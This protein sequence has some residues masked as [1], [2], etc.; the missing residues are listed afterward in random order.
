MNSDVTNPIGFWPPTPVRALAAP[1]LAL[2][3]VLPLPGCL[4]LG[5]VEGTAGSSGGS[6][7]AGSDEGGAPECDPDRFSPICEDGRVLE[8]IGEGTIRSRGCGS[9]ASCQL[10]SDGADCVWPLGKPCDSEYRLC[11]PPGGVHACVD[12]TWEF[13]PCP[14]G[15]TCSD[16]RCYGPEHIPCDWPDDAPYCNGDELVHCA[17]N[18]FETASMCE[19]GEVCRPGETGASCVAEAAEPCDPEAGSVCVAEAEILLCG[20]DGWT[21]RVSCPEAERCFSGP[22]GASC[23][24]ESLPA[25]DP[26]TAEATCVDGTATQCQP[27]GYQS[28]HT[29]ERD[30]A[31]RIDETCF[32]TC[33]QGAACVPPDATPCQEPQDLFCDGEGLAL[34][35]DGWILPIFPDCG[36]AVTGD[37]PECTFE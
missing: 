31:C 3:A 17:P 37:G 6:P 11:K 14:P 24:D 15:G 2:M 27:T 22:L 9:N 30:E 18:G 7:G 4:E 20:E 5:G 35:F 32:G 26:T 12:G 10:G 25:C 23:Q 28:E 16:G 33:R 29:C 36:C 13:E 8:C 19:P 1:V 34:C 21:A